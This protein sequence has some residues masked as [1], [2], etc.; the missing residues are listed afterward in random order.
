MSDFHDRKILI[1]EDEQIVVDL[2]QLVLTRA[3]YPNIKSTPSGEEGLLIARQWRPHLIISDILHA[4]I[5]GIEICRELFL[6][7][8]TL[9]THFIIIS[10]CSSGDRRALPAKDKNS[11]VSLYLTKP[12]DPRELVRRV[13]QIFR[14]AQADHDRGL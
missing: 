5:D 10:G 2:Y 6:D 14:V 11:G 4:G 8:N 12:V 3:G 13:E 7:P 1:I 9:S